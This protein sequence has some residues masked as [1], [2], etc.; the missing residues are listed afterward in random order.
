[1]VPFFDSGSAEQWINL[2]K[3]LKAVLKG[4]NVTSGPA[5][6]AVAKTLLK[7]D[8]LTVF[9]ASE[10]SYSTVTL[11]NFERCLDDVTAHVFP[12]KVVH[13]QKRYMHHSLLLSKGKAVKEWV[14]RL[15]KLNKYLCEFPKVN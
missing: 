4:Q 6:Y 8:A 11:V 15:C 5:K 9:K 12:E 7:G 2:Q 10:T 14:A 13:T 1:M 3:N